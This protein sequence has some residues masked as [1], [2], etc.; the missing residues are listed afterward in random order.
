[1]GREIEIFFIANH[2]QIPNGG[3]PINCEIEINLFE[4]SG[5]IR[6]IGKNI[7]GIN[8]LIIKS[9]GGFFDGYF[10]KIVKLVKSQ[11]KCEDYE[12]NLIFVSEK[13]NKLIARR[14]Y[15]I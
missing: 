13:E 8:E 14:D 9:E 10:K 2:T 12:V 7:V 5:V 15:I 6:L 11:V 4:K 3:E 1:M